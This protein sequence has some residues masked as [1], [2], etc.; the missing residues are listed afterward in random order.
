M[1]FAAAHTTGCGYH[2]ENVEVHFIPPPKW[3]KAK[4]DGVLY[5]GK[6]YEVEFD[7]LFVKPPQ[8]EPSCT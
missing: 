2:V 1:E 8:G 4:G 5:D 6:A 3:A 7:I